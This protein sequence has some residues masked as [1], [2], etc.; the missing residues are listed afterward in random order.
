MERTSDKRGVI[1]YED[2]AR[3]LVVNVTNEGVIFDAY[4]KDNES[5]PVGSMAMT[6]GEWWDPLE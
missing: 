6:A 3:L 4:N 1:A 2:G 5:E